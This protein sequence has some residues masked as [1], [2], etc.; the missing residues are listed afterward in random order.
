MKSFHFN[1]IAKNNKENAE[2]TLLETTLLHVRIQTAKGIYIIGQM[3]VCFDL[4]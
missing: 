3:G 1:F 2:T 4:Y